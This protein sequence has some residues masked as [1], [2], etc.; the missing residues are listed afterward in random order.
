MVLLKKKI[1]KKKITA[2]ITTS[3]IESY[4][5]YCLFQTEKIKPSIGFH[6]SQVTK[7]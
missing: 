7:G 5:K 4:K 1:L 6:V 3:Y 2:L